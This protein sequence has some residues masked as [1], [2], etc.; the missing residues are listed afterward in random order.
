MK[1]PII[2]SLIAIISILL[3]IGFIAI[4][5]D[6]MSFLAK[7]LNTNIKTFS[8]VVLVVFLI[9]L[10]AIVLKNVIKQDKK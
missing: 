10:G 5:T 2:F 1:K 6:F 4:F 7:K 8:S 3:F 9:V